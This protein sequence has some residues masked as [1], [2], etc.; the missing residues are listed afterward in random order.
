MLHYAWSPLRYLEEQGA[1]LG[2]RFVMRLPGFPPIVILSDPAD[3]ADMFRGDPDALHSGSANRFLALTLG[4]SSVLVLDGAAH[5]RQRR[6]L[7]PSMRGERLAELGEVFLA[8]AREEVE[9]WRPD[10]VFEALPAMRRLTLRV[11]LRVVLGIEPG[12]EEAALAKKLDRMLAYGRNRFS[13]HVAAMGAMLPWRRLRGSRVLP[14]FRELNAVDDALL[15]LIRARRERRGGRD[16]LADL[17]AARHEDG[18]S[19][20]DR[21][22]RDAV[23]TMLVAGHD[24]TAVA[25]AW[26]LELCLPRRDVLDAI[27]AERVAVCG[28]TSP[29]PEHLARLPYLDA[30]IRETL[31]CRTVIAF[32]VREVRAPVDVGGRRYEPGSILA[33]C[34]HL[35][36]RRP[37]LY[38]DPD[39]FRPERH[40]ERRFGAHE[41]FPLGGGTRTCLGMAFAM[42]EMKAVLS[43]IFATVGLERPEG[44]RSRPVRLGL[45]L[46]PDDGVRVRVRARSANGR[47]GACLGSP[48]Q[49]GP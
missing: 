42:L 43:T 23:V 39:A 18:A 24:T 14:F 6:T 16:L 32:V 47:D 20:S 45:A 46:S 15:A 44:A 21:E 35:V 7:S 49:E 19:L 28:D 41:F 1:R 2:P 36:H 12:R 10:R 22:I 33:P 8:A 30:V 25:L 38:P 3:V 5:A 17:L 27:R 48:H 11:M 34:I 29:G 26:A 9:G 31:R 13:L 37:D 40:L 4:D